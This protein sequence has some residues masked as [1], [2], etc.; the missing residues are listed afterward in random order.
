[1]LA[2]QRIPTRSS[3]KS[4]QP[5]SNDSRTEDG[6]GCSQ[7]QSTTCFVS[8][9]VD[10]HAVCSSRGNCM[11]SGVRRRF[12]RPCSSLTCR[13]P[14][15]PLTVISC[16]TDVFARY[17]V[18]VEA[19]AA[20]LQASEKQA[21]I[22]GVGYKY[23]YCDGRARYCTG[24]LIHG[25]AQ[26]EIIKNASASR[27]GRV[28]FAVAVIL[29]GDTDFSRHVGILWTKGGTRNGDISGKVLQV[30]NALYTSTTP[31]CFGQL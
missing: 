29:R 18:P 20:T 17:G 27:V 1:M 16:W 22:L 28:R 31:V 30:R 24:L 5:A 15:I 23:K 25:M 4:W 8:R 11:G 7:E 19:I 9:M 13:T 14:A 2:Q 12:R 3:W 21:V 10:G 26:C 6:Q